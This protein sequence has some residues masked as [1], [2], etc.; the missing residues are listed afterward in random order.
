MLL[1]MAGT[2]LVVHAVYEERA[3]VQKANP[4][5]VYKFIPRDIYYDQFFSNKLEDFLRDEAP[6]AS[7]VRPS[8]L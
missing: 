8:P 1:L 3:R 2:L 5:I 7:S 6:E 4:K